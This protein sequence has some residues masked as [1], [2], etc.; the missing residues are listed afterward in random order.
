[1][2]VGL[3]R[4]MVKLDRIIGSENTQA[5]VESDIVVPDSKPDVHNILS[6]EGNVNIIDKEIMQ[7][8]IVVQGVIN[9][10]LLYTSNDPNGFLY[11]MKATDEFTQNI[12]I[13]NIDGMMEAEVN[14]NIEHMDFGI[15]N[16]RKVSAQTVL[17]LNGKVYKTEEMDIVKDIE[18][19]EDIQTLKDTV[20]YDNSVGSNSSQTVL[21]ENFELGEND[22]EITEIL[23][24]N[25]TVVVNE[26][27]VTDNKVIIGGNV[28]IGILYATEE[29]RTP[30]HELKHEI[31]FTHFIEIPKAENDMDSKV[32]VE[33]DE[34]YTNVKKNINEENKVYDVEV[35][36]KANAKVY[37]K[38]KKEVLL[39]AYSPTRKLNIQTKDLKFLKNIG[40]NSSHGVIKE[41]ID[42]PNDYPN[43]FKVLT[44]KARPVITDNKIIDNKNIIEGFID[45]KVL[46]MADNEEMQVYSFN[47]EIPFRHYIEIEGINEDMDMDVKL[48]IENTD[49]STINSKQIETKF[50]LNAYGEANKED[51]M[52]VLVDVEDLG[53]AYDDDNRASIT[54]YFVQ[55]GDN[56]WDIAK[57]YNTTKKEILKTNEISEIEEI[58]PGDKIIIQ[59]NY[60]YKF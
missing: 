34:V 20:V 47:Q 33:I 50:N 41:T 38:V 58:K 57:R 24:T 21:R 44:V 11:N 49:Y 59:K 7:G 56:L 17:N 36:L 27:K 42:I 6:A 51:K 29:P 54:V 48:N 15:M 45:A 52:E 43:I 35:V 3:V 10:K 32:E 14:C 16:E 2:S 8:K 30:I 55:E 60:E 53:E 40:R 13:D 28:N 1:M 39:D 46:Y 37:K 5:H 22:A 12:E 26:K 19:L 23:E 9:Y 31:P 25:G 18:G 4:E